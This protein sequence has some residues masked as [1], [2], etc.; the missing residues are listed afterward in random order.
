[1]CVCVCVYVAVL[2]AMHDHRN[3]HTAK[4]HAI[5]KGKDWIQSI[6]PVC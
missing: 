5:S 1:V 4:L 2:T 6:W 3:T